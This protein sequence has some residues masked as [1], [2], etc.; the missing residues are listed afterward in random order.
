MNWQHII[1]FEMAAQEQHISRAAEKLSITQPAL[2]MAIRA[3]EQELGVPLFYKTG[4]NVKL[5]R[6]GEMFLVHVKNATNSI[7]KGI[8]QIHDEQRDIGGVV[9]V[10]SFFTFASDIL[11]DIIFAFQRMYPEVEFSSTER[12]TIELLELVR[13]GAIDIGICTQVDFALY[14]KDI[15]WVQILRDDIVVF[16][17]QNH[18]LAQKDAI[19]FEECRN[20]PLVSFVKNSEYRKMVAAWFA[21]EGWEVNIGA[22][23]SNAFTVASYVKSGLGI[24]FLPNSPAIPRDGIKVLR[25]KDR[26]FTRGIYLA[27][28]KTNY[29]S[30]AART[31]RDFVIQVAENDLF[32][33]ISP[34]YGKDFIYHRPDEPGLL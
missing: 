17:P 16:V 29:L 27:W 4:R 15:S 9:N 18:P 10:S 28:S 5:T 12:G 3:L 13:E 8:Q 23:A 34:S 7:R 25:V 26:K 21:A 19:R 2:S 30:P 24:A 32:S 22:S 6:F 11:G 14:E 20:E 1:Y 31:F 33:H